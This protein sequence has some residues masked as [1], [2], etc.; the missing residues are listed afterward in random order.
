MLTANTTESEGINPPGDRPSQ[1]GLFLASL[2]R[3]L[4]GLSQVRAGHRR[5]SVSHCAAP[6]RARGF[7][8]IETLVALLV[9]AVAYAGVTT[10]VAQFVD[11]RLIL[12]E[13]HS[14]HRIAWNR[15]MEQYLVSLKL[16]V[17]EADFGEEAGVVSARGGRWRWQFSEEKAAA[18]GLVR[19]QVDVY[20][21][22]ASDAKT[23][24]G[25]ESATGSLAAFF[26]R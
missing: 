23:G 6:A 2:Q 4:R 24:A 20:P 14:S 15:L 21:V 25:S 5:C 11:Q 16:P 12:V 10:A 18:E 3:C 7:T 17:N 13:R 26:T 9:V 22:E 1:R 19:Y 8:L